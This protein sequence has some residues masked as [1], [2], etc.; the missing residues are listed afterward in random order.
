MP[1]STLLDVY[2]MLIDEAFRHEVVK[3]IQD[4]VVRMF[5]ENVFAKWSERFRQEALAPVENKVGQLLTG[6]LLRNIIGQARGAI[7]VEQILKGK[8]IF[9]VNLSKGRIGEDRANLL[10]SIVI[11]KLYLAALERQA[12]PE[13]ERQDFYLY[14]DEAHAFTT[15]TFSSILS[16]SRK[17]RLNL[18]LGHQ[19]LEQM[20]QHIQHSIFG[21]IGTWIVFRV[22][23]E[24]A[25]V[26]ESEFAPYIKPEQLRRQAN[27]RMS[28]KLL[29]N[30]VSA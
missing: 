5:W 23:A 1:Q 21:N 12:I 28:Y 7:D 2:R 20:P 17:Y 24:D 27:Y 13:S 25:Q 19:Y 22:G 26:L 10:G 30:G 14:I 8:S 18:I 15:T 4:P 29:V 9:L 11:T 16:E 6:S 3:H